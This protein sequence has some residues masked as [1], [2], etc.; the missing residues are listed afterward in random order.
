[1]SPVT[2]NVH[3]SSEPSVPETAVCP[4]IASV[5]EDASAHRAFTVAVV[6]VT[7]PTHANS[8]VMATGGAANDV[9]APA[10]TKRRRDTYGVQPPVMSPTIAGARVLLA[11]G[12]TGPAGSGWLDVEFFAIVE[13]W[14]DIFDMMNVAVLLSQDS[15]SQ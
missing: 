3:I 2:L 8:T 10:A 11:A 5:I 6:S 1:M 15:A 7:A 13:P 14:P 12:V 4:V 9:P